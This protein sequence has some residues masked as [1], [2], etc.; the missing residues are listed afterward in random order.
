M[1]KGRFRREK[2]KRGERQVAEIFRRLLGTPTRRGRQY[3][4]L[5]APDVVDHIPETHCEVKLQEKSRLDEWFDQAC[6]DAKPGEVP[7]VVHRRSNRPWM[8]TF[9]FEDL[10]RFFRRL[11]L[12]KKVRPLK[13]KKNA[14]NVQDNSRGSGRSTKNQGS[15]L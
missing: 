8:I 6:K 5:G 10:L 15:I 7:F 3:S 12:V 11:L 13:G 14:A 2:G 1:G 9:R 4:G